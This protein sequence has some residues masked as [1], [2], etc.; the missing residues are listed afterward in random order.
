MT[1]G[2]P[3]YILIAFL[4]IIMKL[5]VDQIPDEGL[6]L[7]Y[8][9]PAVSFDYLKEEVGAGA[10]VVGPIKISLSVKKGSNGVIVT[11]RLQGEASV[12]CSRCLEEITE[13]ISH[14]FSYNCL[15]TEIMD[16]EEELSKESTDI[17]YYSGGEIDVT[18]LI[19]EQAA[20]ALP[21]RPLCKEDCK[22]LCPKCGANLNL[23]DCGCKKKPMD[24][25]FAALKDLKIK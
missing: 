15:S 17:C 18:G 13:D 16:E 7:D 25:R 11:G 9:E 21:M 3:L 8:Q 1:K 12:T 4:K 23:G 10:K 20:L 19:Q 24:L 5:Y 22:G 14:D 2:N 6:K